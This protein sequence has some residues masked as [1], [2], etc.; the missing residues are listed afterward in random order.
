MKPG[1]RPRRVPQELSSLGAGTGFS[2]A[3]G[4]W[5]VLWVPGSYRVGQSALVAQVTAG[6]ERRAQVWQPVSSGLVW[7]L[8]GQDGPWALGHGHGQGYV[9]SLLGSSVLDSSHLVSL[10]VYL[11]GPAPMCSSISG[12]CLVYSPRGVGL[13]HPCPSVPFQDFET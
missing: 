5:R 10:S 2:H 6:G 9:L 13:F 4:S 1:L 8:Q 12:L 3:V 11:L 7:P